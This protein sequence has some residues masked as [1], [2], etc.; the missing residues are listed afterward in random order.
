[1]KFETFE[2]IQFSGVQFF[3]GTG[4]P[5]VLGCRFHIRIPGIHTPFVHLNSVFFVIFCLPSLWLSLTFSFIYSTFVLLLFLLLLFGYFLFC[6]NIPSH[7]PARFPLH[8]SSSSSIFISFAYGRRVLFVIIV[9]IVI[10]HSSP[11][12][13]IFIP[14]VVLS[15]MKAYLVVHF[16]LVHFIRHLKLL[17]W[18]K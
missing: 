4:G 6:E 5:C 13:F 3:L 14:L 15:I 9:C 2:Y 12:I 10:H 16:C 1:M 11:I 7:I 17:H 18:L 8:S